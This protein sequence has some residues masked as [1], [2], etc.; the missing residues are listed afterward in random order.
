M[1]YATVFLMW[2]FI[3]EV[4]LSMYYLYTMNEMPKTET[5]EPKGKFKALG[6]MAASW[7]K[8]W[9]LFVVSLLFFFI[10][11]GSLMVS[12]IDVTNVYDSSGN[13]RNT[14]ETED[15]RLGWEFLKIMIG[16]VGINLGVLTWRTINQTRI[17][18][19]IFGSQAKSSKKWRGL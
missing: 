3:A 19:L 8:S 17:M 9:F 5:E 18:V 4:I 14:I 7:K 1:T 16:L 13:I 6:F 12:M 11:Y 10:F 2:S 15:W